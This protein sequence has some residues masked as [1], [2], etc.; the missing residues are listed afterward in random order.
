MPTPYTPVD[1]LVTGH[2][3]DPES[4][5]AAR[6]E[7]RYR[8]LVVLS[9]T[10]DDPGLDDLTRHEELGGV[11]VQVIPVDDTD[12]MGILEVAQGV[13][14][15]HKED[16][17]RIHV[18]GGPNLVTSALLLAA[19]QAGLPA[20]FCHSVGPSAPGAPGRETTAHLPVLVKASVEDRFRDI[21]RAILVALDP[22]GHTRPLVELAGADWTM[23]AVRSALLRLKGL[24]VV[25]A[26]PQEACLT[27]T[28]RWFADHLRNMV[29]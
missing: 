28:G 16:H 3:H 26:T 6:R 11:E 2:G 21:D 12:L 1:V 23:S 14:A 9:S 18:G 27:P 22:A 29:R 20:F 13:G 10:P 24:G 15:A 5:Q 8:K 19:Y 17:I 7:V 25:H 4:V